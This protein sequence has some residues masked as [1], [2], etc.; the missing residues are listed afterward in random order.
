MPFQIWQLFPHVILLYS[1]K[2]FFYIFNHLN[3]F[4]L[5]YLSYIAIQLSKV[6]RGLTWLLL[7]PLYKSFMSQVGNASPFQNIF[8]FFPALSWLFVSPI[9]RQFLFKKKKN[10]VWLLPNRMD[11]I[12][13]LPKT[14]IKHSTVVMNLGEEREE[15]S[16]FS[17]PKTVKLPVLF[18]A[19]EQIFL[20]HPLTRV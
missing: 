3:I 5:Y 12:N 11:S 20:V 7:S 14:Q 17:H 15:G 18:C 9:W 8:T 13:S 1:F 6:L 19:S 2:S 4:I 10:V 16:L